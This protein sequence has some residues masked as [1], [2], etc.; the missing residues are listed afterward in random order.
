MRVTWQRRAR[1][2]RGPTESRWPA[3][4]RSSLQPSTSTGRPSA[5]RRTMCSSC[6]NPCMV[7]DTPC[8]PFQG[9]AHGPDQMGYTGPLLAYG[10]C[11]S[12]KS[13]TGAAMELHSV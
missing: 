12:D 1:C 5:Q 13:V 10:G 8:E 7:Q 3:S 9:Q 4:W 6:G 2:A 11:D